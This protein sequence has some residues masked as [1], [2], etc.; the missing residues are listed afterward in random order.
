MIP[1]LADKCGEFLQ[2]K[3]CADNAAMLLDQSMFFNAETLKKNVLDFIQRQA[4]KVF[5]SDSFTGLSHHAL[6]EVLSLEDMNATEL[7]VFKACVRW[8]TTQCE[9]QASSEECSDENNPKPAPNGL[10]LRE[11]LGDNLFLLRFPA[12]SLEEFN[13]HVAPQELLTEGEGYRIFRYITAKIT[14]SLP[15]NISPR[16]NPYMPRIVQIPAPYSQA[17][18]IVN[19]GI[20]STLTCQLSRPIILTKVLIHMA[21]DQPSRYNQHITGYITQNK[22]GLAKLNESSVVPNGTLPLHHKI[23]VNNVLLEAGKVTIN[24]K[25]HHNLN[26]PHYAYQNVQ[27]SMQI[28]NPAMTTLSD[29]YIKLDFQPIQNNIFLGIEYKLPE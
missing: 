27:V 14:K 25:F 2:N 18:F 28:T 26:N 22:K 23:D 12:L 17:Q 19:Q 11:A 1:G 29:E 20:S 15:F 10:Q 9:K 5:L 24:V 13:E 4:Y 3:L 7:D 16:V 21:P 6:K 8:A